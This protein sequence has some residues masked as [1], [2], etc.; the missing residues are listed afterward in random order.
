MVENVF[1]SFLWQPMLNI[2]SKSYQKQYIEVALTFLLQKAETAP[3]INECNDS[4]D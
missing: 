2:V 1:G 4:N 3:Q